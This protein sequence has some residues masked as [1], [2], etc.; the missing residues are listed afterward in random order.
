MALVLTPQHLELRKRDEPKR[1]AAFSSILSAA[2]WPIDVSSAAGAAKRW[3][4]P[5]VSKATFADVLI[6]LP[7]WGAMRLCWRP[8]V[9]A[10]ML[11]RN[12][13]VAALLDDGSTR[14]Y[15]DAGYWRLALRSVC[16]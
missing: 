7:D 11:E 5:L 2:R 12:P 13:V 3:R 16:S 9:A 15:A 4:K 14:G 6:N 10:W 1:S 8:S